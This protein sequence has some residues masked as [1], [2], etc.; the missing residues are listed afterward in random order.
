MP[1]STREVKPA[2]APGGDRVL[3]AHPV[4]HEGAAPVMPRRYF[5]KAPGGMLQSTPD[6]LDA[7]SLQDAAAVERRKRRRIGINAF[8]A[9][10]D[11]SAISRGR[12]RGR[13]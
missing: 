5:S 6:D 1:S 13:A 2:A 8:C 3:Q 9:S 10:R 11:Y 7:I 4:E 12:A